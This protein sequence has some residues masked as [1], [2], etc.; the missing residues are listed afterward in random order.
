MVTPLAG[1]KVL[2]I[3]AGLRFQ[4]VD[5]RII[6]KRRPQL[7]EPVILQMPEQALLLTVI[8]HQLRGVVA[9]DGRVRAVMKTDEEDPMCHTVV[10]IVEEPRADGGRAVG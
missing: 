7:Q 1:L 10:Q 5:A 6:G 3:A 9:I 8:H 4:R 2:D